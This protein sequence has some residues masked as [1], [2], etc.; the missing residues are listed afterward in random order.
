MKTYLYKLKFLSPLHISSDPLSL[1]KAEVVL[2][3]D[4]LFS[5]IA[6]AFALLFDVKDEFFF[7][8]PFLISSA[9]PYYNKTLFLPKPFCPF[10]SPQNE[11]FRKEIKKSGFISMEIFRKFAGGEEINLSKENF[12]S[13][14]FITE[15]PIKYMVYKSSERPRSTV[16]RVYGNTEIFYSTS[17]E[18]GENSGLY[19]FVKFP[20]EQVKKEFDSAL[21]LLG[22]TGIGGERSAGYGRFEFASNEFNLPQNSEEKYFMAISLYYPTEEEINAGIL[23]N[24]RYALISRQNWVFSGKAQPIRSKKVRMFAEGSIFKTQGDISGQI[25]DV[26]PEL[27]E[28]RLP[29]RIVRYG[30]VFKIGISEKAISQEAEQ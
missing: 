10:R 9:F 7:S 18:F 4:T 2:H 12:A 11:E 19:F 8:P 16:S 21:Y 24:A 30:K 1:G 28:I 17:V 6:N 14:G 20:D 29:H 13:G 23:K 3:S 22:D 25:V 15:T 26:T 5:A 27:A